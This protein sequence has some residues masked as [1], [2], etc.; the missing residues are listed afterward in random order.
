MDWDT[1]KNK[2]LLKAEAVVDE[3]IRHLTVWARLQRVH[4]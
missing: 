3:Q 1:M 4:N 2:H